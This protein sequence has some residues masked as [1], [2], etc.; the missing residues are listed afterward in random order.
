MLEQLRT[1]ISS[2]QKIAMSYYEAGKGLSS[3]TIGSEREVFLHQVLQKIFP[4]QYRFS[5]GDLIDRN[6]LSANQIDLALEF[7]FEPTFPMPSSEQR[8]MLADSIICTFE[9]KSIFS[10]WAQVTKKAKMVKALDRDVKWS[11]AM[12][13]EDE[14]DSPIKV[15]DINIFKKIPIIAIFYNGPENFETLKSTYEKTPPEERPDAVLIL[16]KGYFISETVEYQKEEGVLAFFILISKLYSYVAVAQ[17]NLEA[18]I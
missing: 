4:L 16:D 8:L 12:G 7:P 14:K 1:R 15:V 13:S 2:I 3:P 10:Q 6:G 5:C 18:Y 9:V 11:M 17:P